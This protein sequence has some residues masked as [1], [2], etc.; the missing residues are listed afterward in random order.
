M[1]VLQKPYGK[2]NDLNKW[3]MTFASGENEKPRGTQ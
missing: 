3:H 2:C 1:T